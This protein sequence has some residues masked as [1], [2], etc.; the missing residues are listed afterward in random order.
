MVIGY[1]RPYYGAEHN[2]RRAGY[3]PKFVEAIRHC[4]YPQF[5]WDKLPVTGVDESILRFD[6]IRPIGAHYNSY[7]MTE[8]YLSE[9]AM[10]IMDDMI[11]WLIFGK[12]QEDSFLS[13]YRSEIE[14]TFG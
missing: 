6:H 13:L 10:S 7:S 4:E 12:V 5:F 14:A 2:N 11:E 1:C 8:Y 3:N 9:D